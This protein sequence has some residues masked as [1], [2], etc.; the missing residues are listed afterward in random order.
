MF[1]CFL[2]VQTKKHSTENKRVHLRMLN[3]KPWHDPEIWSKLFLRRA[4]V[5]YLLG[6]Q[7]V[8]K[9]SIRNSLSLRLSEV[10]RFDSD[11]FS[12]TC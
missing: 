10:K 1:L 2:E 11:L 6:K 4:N 3:A 7:N 12:N 9:N 5:K 8:P